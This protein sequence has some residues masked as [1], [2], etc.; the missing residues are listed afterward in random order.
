MP[1]FNQPL[2]KR[3]FMETLKP[4]QDPREA[5]DVSHKLPA[6]GFVKGG[7]HLTEALGK[8]EIGL[9]PSEISKGPFPYGNVFFHVTKR[10]S[11]HKE[12]S[13]PVFCPMDLCSWRAFV[14]AGI[15]LY[16]GVCLSSSLSST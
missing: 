7:T 10:C 12:W 15:E 1:H 14:V 5:C 2:G 3:Q 16:L 9:M 4:K 11:Y 8:S 6:I 13:K